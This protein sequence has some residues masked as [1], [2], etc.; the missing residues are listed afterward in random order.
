MS[1]LTLRID[2][3][4]IKVAEG[5]SILDAAR[6]AGIYIPT[7]CS[8]P[9]LPPQG[10]CGLCAVQVEGHNE[11]VFACETKA[12]TG[13]IIVTNTPAIQDLR[14]RKLA[15]I[16]ENH[17]HAC[18]TCAQREGC[19]RSQCSSGVA[20]DERCC[21]KLGQC[22]LQKVADYV[23]IRPDVGRYVYK[24][25]PVVQD[26]PLFIRDNNLCIGCLRCVRACQDLRGVGAIEPVDIEG[27]RRIQPKAATLA[28]SDCRF[29]TACVEVCPTGALRDKE[30]NAHNREEALLPCTH[31][32]PAHIDIP[33]F[34]R[35]IAEEKFSEANAIVREKVPFPG[36]LGR[37]CFHPCEQKCR[38]GRVNVPVSIC[39]LKRYAADND[40]GLWKKNSKVKSATGKK[41]AVV[42][43]GPAGLT[44]AFYLAKAGHA[45]TV[46]EA[47]PEPGG[48]MRVGIQSYRLPRE[49]L[50]AEIAEITA[51]GVEIKTDTK[52]NS[53]DEL[54][55]YDATF[56]A[57]GAHLGSKMGITGEDSPGVYDGVTFLRDVAL[58]RET[59]IG[60]KVAVVG[61]GNVAV[62]AA[63]TALRL[64]AQEV[65]IYYCRIGDEKPVFK[66]ALY[67]GV[68]VENQWTPVSIESCDGGLSLTIQ[69]IQ[70]TK[71]DAISQKI[72]ET[73]PEETKIVVV[74]SIIVAMGRKPETNNLGIS[75]GHGGFITVDEASLNVAECNNV[76]AGG[77]VVGGPTS[78]VQAVAHGRQ[79]AA[80]IDRVLGGDG[81][82]DEQLVER[83]QAKPY[84]GREEGFAFAK[85]FWTGQRPWQ[86]AISGAV[87]CPS[88]ELLVACFNEV[89]IGFHEQMAIDEASRCLRC[90]LRLE[91]QQVVLPPD[92]WLGLNETDVAAVPNVEGV[93]QLLDEEKNILAIVGTATLRE[94]LEEQL[95]NASKA[96][97]FG[98]EEE[99]MYSQRE[100][101]LIQQYLQEHGK[102]PEGT[103]DLDDLF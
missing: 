23:G 82:I 102:L 4:D 5:A 86:K 91:I 3:T 17:P 8:H 38:R 11:P 89:D 76:F 40:D 35:L 46:F 63:R 56:L 68:Q 12:V 64:G 90:E 81:I 2:E 87:S 6:E 100:S 43:A 22:E 31:K 13:M 34:V 50:S 83:E 62:D 7:L 57:I 39:G 88:A 36:S 103:G 55:S 20:V 37:V 61:G 77:D 44:A 79:A 30:V 1:I 93:Y 73:S 45:V 101:Q 94:A 92:K 66:E 96:K 72:A 74:N 14:Q 98:Y 18:L 9:D 48:M 16:L 85:R 29:C 84:L 52:I 42:G 75:V 47:L 97:Y 51:V 10:D 71:P 99:P 33:R 32:C 80:S 78:V 65:T 67:E 21:P 25:L 58:N 54:Q 27:T 49:V 19:S 15:A 95:V 69:R 26:E 70:P 41:V 60:N 24:A 53:L 59:K 28:E